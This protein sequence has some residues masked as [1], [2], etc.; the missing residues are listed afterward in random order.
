VPDDTLL[1][2]TGDML[3]T[4]SDGYFQSLPH[5][6]VNSN[7]QQRFRFLFFAVPRHVVTV[8]PLVAVQQDRKFSSANAGEK[9][10]EIWHS[11]WPGAAPV[12]KQYDPYTQ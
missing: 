9:S 8:E 7:R 5:K 6:V 11:I 2:N 4:W 12:E 1:V 3:E 10:R